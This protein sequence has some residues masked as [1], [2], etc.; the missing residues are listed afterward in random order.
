MFPVAD[1]AFTGFDRASAPVNRLTMLVTSDG[2]WV[3]EDDA[4]FLDALGDPAPDYDAASFAVK[5]L[6]FIKFQ[7]LDDS[8]IEIDLHPRNVELPALLAIQQQLLT[9]NVRLFR[10]KY[11]DQAW[12]SEITSS[13]DQA[14]SRLSELCA[15][16]FSLPSAE[17]FLIE[18]D[19]YTKLFADS[20]TPLRPLL[21][22]WR[23]SFGHFDS[24]VI[25][26]AVE[27]E[28]W[29]RMLIF[30]LKPS[31]FEPVF[32]FVG[33]RNSNGIW[34][35]R[36]SQINVI[37]EK[38]AD[39]PDK[40]Y[41]A[42]VSQFYKS[43][44]TTGQPRYDIVTAAIRTSGDRTQSYVT[45]YERLLLPWKTPSEEVFVTMWSKRLGDEATDTFSPS[46]TSSSVVRK[47]A[48]SS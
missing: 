17:R 34:L 48:K 47:L 1:C 30:G 24:T 33:A 21:Q 8:I 5:N 2:Q 23:M 20:Q 41:G 28:L 10:I 6:G 15:P 32:R 12:H 9:S 7:L 4:A 22:K 18:P 19:D 16:K 39:Q 42:W 3:L 13:R 46:D 14:I 26:L 36:D 35:G 31:E 37:G 43:V 27:H 45:R 44:A 25:S 38:V 29:P 11:F 40:E